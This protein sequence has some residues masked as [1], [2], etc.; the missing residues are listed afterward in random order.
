MTDQSVTGVP[1]L[2]RKV[3]RGLSPEIVSA[4]VATSSWFPPQMLMAQA[5]YGKALSY[6]PDR[7]WLGRTPDETA[8]PVGFIDDRHIVTIAGSRAGKGVSSIIPVLCEYPGSVLCFDPKGDNARCTAARRGFGTH[9]P[10]VVGFEQDVFVLDPSGI[11]GVEE[12]YLATFDPLD[13]LG[14]DNERTYEETGLIADGLFV[15]TDPKDAHWDDSARDFVQALILHVLS[16]PSYAGDRTLG[17]VRK[18]LRDGERDEH[19]AFQAYLTDQGDPDSD[20]ITKRVSAFDTLLSVMSE[21]MAFDG[22]IAG[23]A[24]GLMDLGER[25]RGSILSTA[26]RNLKFLDSPKMQKCLSTSEHT[27]SLEMLKRNPRGVSVFVVLPSRLMKSH[28]RW[29]RLL[30]NLVIARMEIDAEPPETGHPVLAICD[31]FPVLGHMAM[32]ESAV[33]YMAGFGLK[34]WAILQDLPQLKRHYPQSWETFLGNAGTLQFFGNADQTTLEFISRRLGEIEVLRETENQS[35]TETESEADISEFE[36]VRRTNEGG[37]GKGLFSSFDLQN[38][39]QTPSRSTATSKTR[40]QTIQ[41]TALMTPDEIRRVFSRASGLQII[42]LADY[43]PM[44]L[45]RTPYF[46]DPQFTGK[47][48][49]SR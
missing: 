32:L 30:L 45:R 3:L 42:S 20:A 10:H 41:K 19:Q 34:I 18:L 11:S 28:S 47:F 7:L 49:P 25:E 12:S 26:R 24:T 35:T 6:R 46:S 15:P 37:K 4:P 31:E 16:W 1:E 40:S 8:L 33:G 29:M 44:I 38:N 5:G 21:N 14:P 9:H 17:R 23:A 2:E 13:G 43:R 36:K 48:T 27:L 22:A 39:T